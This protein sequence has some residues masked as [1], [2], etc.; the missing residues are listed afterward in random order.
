M[1]RAVL[2]HPVKSWFLHCTTGRSSK[3]NKEDK[4]EGMTESKIKKF[5]NC[6]EMFIRNRIICI[7]LER[8]KCV[9]H[10]QLWRLKKDMWKTFFY[11]NFWAFL[12]T[13]PTSWL[14]RLVLSIWCLSE[15][16]EFDIFVSMKPENCCIVLLPVADVL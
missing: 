1:K 7:S 3:Q 13:A 8:E 14:E 2:K 4:F 5:F 11:Q 10:P 15:S 9:K 12:I 16:K 6:L